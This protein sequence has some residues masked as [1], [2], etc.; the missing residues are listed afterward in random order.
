MPRARLLL[1]LAGLL[2]LIAAPAWSQADDLGALALRLVNE[3]RA[4]EGLPALERGSRL[5]EAAR[6]HARDMLEQ[7]YYAH[8]SPE[9]QGPRDR[10]LATGG[11][12]G[13]LV[14]E[15]IAR[16]EGC[17]TPPGP[18]RA[19][20]FHRGWMQS[21]GHREN[22]LAEGL[23]RFGFGLASGDDTTLAVQVFAGP[24]TPPHA[25]PGEEPEQVDR[26]EA[27]AEALDAVNAA[28]AERDLP[29]LEPS[30]DLRAAASA[31]DREAE[32]GEDGLRLPADPFALLPEEAEG[33]RSLA[34]SAETCTGCGAHR[35]RGDAAHF[36]EG[37]AAGGGGGDFTH[38]GFALDA[39]GTGRKTAVAVFG[40][41]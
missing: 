25:A 21:P 15:N 29:P 28:R 18:A 26:D 35:V 33:W 11:G 2:G 39:D 27:E 31:A 19:R 16:C 38:L 5:D 1:L 7:G 37:L 4:E 34:V 14:A 3:A 23:A 41:R 32:F 36:A 12:R 20:S 8:R 6:A 24:G 9:G 22:V 40:R 30:E 10:F 13:S 17:P